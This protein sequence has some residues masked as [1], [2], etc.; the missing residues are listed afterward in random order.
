M[1]GINF[2]KSNKW[3]LCNGSLKADLRFIQDRNIKLSESIVNVIKPNSKTTESLLILSKLLNHDADFNFND[4]KF[5]PLPCSMN[6]CDSVRSS[7][8][9]CTS[10]VRTSK[11]VCSS[12]IHTNKS[13]CTV[14]VHSSKPV[15]TDNV[16]IIKPVCTSH[17]HASKPVCASYVR[18]SKPVC[19]SNFPRS[20][21][22]CDSHERK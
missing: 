17:I 12:H 9:V 11:P 10:N 22:V 18:S 4:K 2:I 1:N 3:T 13:V 14:N 5:P 20:K 19:T 8:P 16:C 21:F 15:Y 7:K 6:V